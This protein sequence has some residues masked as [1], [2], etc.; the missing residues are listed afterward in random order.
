[1]AAEEIDPIDAQEIGRQLARG[2]RV[3]ARQISLIVESLSLFHWRY[4]HQIMAIVC[5]V[6]LTLAAGAR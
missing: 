3:G 2:P 4:S 1:M 5:W 6:G